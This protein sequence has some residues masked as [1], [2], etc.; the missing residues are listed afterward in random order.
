MFDEKW[1]DSI[2]SKIEKADNEYIGENGLLFCAVCKKQTQTIIKVFE[3]QR[4]VRCI[5]DCR[6]REIE[7]QE[8]R[9]KFEEAERQRSICFSETNMAK[10]TFQNDDG[11]NE[12]LTEAM[13][14][15]V[16]N[17]TEFKKDGKGLLLYGTVGTGKTYL[18]AC[19]ANS[20]IDEGYKPCGTCNP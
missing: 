8:K 1:I 5:C 17:F 18:A 7:L 9:K 12:K 15:Y 11:K 20:L 14:N 2:N 16:K 10:W 3:Q 19:V 6:K 13:K 4:L